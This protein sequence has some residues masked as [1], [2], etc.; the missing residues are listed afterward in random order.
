MSKEKTIYQS[1]LN[2]IA[3]KPELPSI[4]DVQYDFFTYDGA[5]QA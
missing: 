4:K 1:R 5:L 2:Q 3:Y